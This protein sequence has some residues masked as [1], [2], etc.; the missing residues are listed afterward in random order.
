MR[1]CTIYTKQFLW[2][3]E[4][5]HCIHAVIEFVSQID[6]NFPPI[7]CPICTTYLVKLIHNVYCS[8]TEQPNIPSLGLTQRALPMAPFDLVPKSSQLHFCATASLVKRV[9]GPHPQGKILQFILYKHVLYTPLSSLTT[10]SQFLLQ[11]CQSLVHPGALISLEMKRA[12]FDWPGVGLS[13]PTTAQTPHYIQFYLCKMTRKKRKTPP[14]C[15]IT[16]HFS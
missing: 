5:T 9:L 12:H 6:M 10:M 4:T 16:L 3:P 7:F 8:L 13:H 2:T 15:T 11:L 14:M 1:C